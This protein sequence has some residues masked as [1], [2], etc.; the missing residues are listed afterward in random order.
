VVGRKGLG[1]GDVERR[2]EPAG[3][4]LRDEGFG[5]DDRAACHVDDEGP[6]RQP[7]QQF[8]VDEAARRAR[9]RD[10]DD[11]DVGTGREDRKLVD[12][13]HDVDE[14]V[15]FPGSGGDDRYHHLERQQPTHDRPA[16][17]AVADDQDPLVR[18]RAPHLR[19]G[20]G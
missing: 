16:D 2:T 6:V 10:D 18:E 19:R 15:P 1:V 14:I 3:G 5:V 13:V 17:P 7:G 11:E 9:E 4:T 12:A 8:S 20:P